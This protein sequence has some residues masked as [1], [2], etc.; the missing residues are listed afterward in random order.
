MLPSRVW[1]ALLAL[2]C[3]A[4]AAVGRYVFVLPSS[5]APNQVQ[6]F[7]AETGQSMGTVTVPATPLA[8]FS[9]YAGTA[10]IIITNSA[11]T[12]V[13]YARI[14]TSGQLGPE[15]VNVS[16]SGTQPRAWTLSPSGAQLAIAAVPDFNPAI[17]TVFFL[18]PNTGQFATPGLKQLSSTPLDVAFSNDGTILAA[19]TTS[20]LSLLRTSDGELLHTYPLPSTIG[21]TAVISVGPNG[22]FYVSGVSSL[23][24]FAS[25]APFQQFGVSGT[26]AYPGR[27]T[28]SPN[29]RYA[30]AADRRPGVAGSYSV[31]GFDLESRN[32]LNDQGAGAPLNSIAIPSGSASIPVAITS[33]QMINSQEAIA[34]SAESG[35]MYV[36][37][38]PS[39]TLRDFVPAGG[40][41]LQGV[42]GLGISGEIPDSRSLWYNQS[43]TLTKYSL[44]GVL[45][46]PVAS[47][48]GR[49][50]FST[51]PSPSGQPVQ[52]LLAYNANQPVTGGQALGR[53]IYVRALD[54]LGRWVANAPVTI[55]TSGGTVSDASTSTNQLG[56]ATATI[57]APSGGGSFTVTFLIGGIS[58]NVVVGS[59]SSGGG[60][61]GGGGGGTP[62]GAGLVMVSGHGGLR[63][64][65]TLPI[66]LKVRAVGSDGKPLA[67]KA[68]QWASTGG[69]QNVFLITD[70]SGGAS[71]N[72]NITDADGYAS[73]TGIMTAPFGGTGLYEVYR[74]YSV[75]ASS[76]VGSFTFT[77][78][79]Y[80]PPAP[81]IFRGHPNSQVLKPEDSRNLRMKLGE[82]LPDAIRISVTALSASIGVT[83]QAV[84]GVGITLTGGNTNPA[85][86]PVV[87]C[88]GLTV[89]T[90]AEGIASCNLRAIGKTG[91]TTFGVDVGTNYQ[92]FGG[93]SI[94]VDP[95]DPLAPEITGGNNQKAQPGQ[96]FSQTLTAVIK[97]GAG[98]PLPNVSVAWEILTAGITI[99]N[100]VNTSDS[101]GR[102]SARVIAGPNAGSFQVRVRITGT[103]KVATYSLT[104]EN[105][106]TGFRKVSGDGQPTVVINTQ[107]PSPLVV[108]VFDQANQPVPN[109]QVNF[110]VTQGSA[111]VSPAVATTNA[112]GQASVT[113]TAGSTAGP[114]QITATLQNFTPITWSLNSRLP[115]PVLTTQSFTN[116]ATGEVGVVPGSLVLITGPGIAPNIRGERNANMLT[117][118]LPYNI[119]GVTVEF[120]YAGQVEYAPML[121]VANIN[122]VETALVQAPYGLA[123]AATTDVRVTS[124]GDITVTGVPVRPVGPGILEDTLGGTRAAIAIRS[125][126]LRVTPS[127]PAR[128]G[129]VVRIYV[130]GLGQTTPQADTNRVGSPDQKIRAAIAA[131]ID[132]KGVDVISAH[133]AE[134]LIAV[135]EVI[136]RIPADATVGNARPLGLVIEPTPG[137]QYYANGSTIAISAQ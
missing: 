137:Q 72:V 104:I 77:L 65:Q 32:P 55:S 95:G 39:M 108:L 54:S 96:E 80:A 61:G 68:I 44:S 66:E 19:L 88:E 73:V 57:T 120:R 4:P 28:F 123:G 75:T 48:A 47:L 12:P 59:G 97:D 132:D 83:T 102:V 129:E 40:L 126:G 131:G 86:G 67:G 130:I 9:N 56:Y 76:D 98:N 53:P 22:S 23:Y 5:G 31:I 42:T 37:S 33:I 74:T 128:R 133:L 13:S 62:G 113:V 136:F 115:G 43:G 41:P 135:Y 58:T 29:G 107:F 25:R 119:E 16:L 84:A 110:A 134:N 121:R 15:V 17:G 38:Y 89:L 70:Y 18:D 91:S 106:V 30:L 101:S 125:D 36:I 94:T 2:L 85:V 117:A 127:F 26:P 78:V 124:G 20:G 103:E 14:D 111:T 45:S 90:N 52:T 60:G 122:G 116:F 50:F 35:R 79:G 24:E 1:I 81:G 6:G 46:P 34:Y 105:V 93:F 112:N 69:D 71:G 92:T 49:V 100:P 63:P 118:Q 3:F 51:L 8:A 99:T 109:V 7:V 11:S 64:I 82:T 21:N 87:F 114:I 10:A 27:L